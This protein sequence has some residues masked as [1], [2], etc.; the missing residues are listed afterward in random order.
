MSK[1]A[2]NTDNNP[3]FV[4]Q[5]IYVEE[6]N[7]KSHLVPHRIK[8]KW[9]PNAHV[10]VKTRFDALTESDY[11]VGIKVKVNVKIKDQDVFDIYVHHSGV[12][13]LKNFS[14]EQ[15]EHLLESYC[16]T[17]LLPYA[18]HKVSDVVQLAGFPPLY[19]APVDFEAK[20]QERK[21][22]EKKN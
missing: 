2:K 22:K 15:R 13:G 8:E 6:V 19:I 7:Y 10:D 21:Q 17:I 4:I 5:N 12:F 11:E 18:R 20:Y 9:E 1:E 3:E 16:P 14:D